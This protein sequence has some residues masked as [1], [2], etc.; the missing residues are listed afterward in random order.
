MKHK[1]FYINKEDAN[2]LFEKVNDSKPTKAGT[3]SEVYIFNKYVVL[4]IRNIKV[5]NVSIRDD[6]LVYFDQLIHTLHEL[7]EDGVKVLPIL[8]YKYDDESEHGTGYIIQYKAK[9]KELYEDRLL[10]KF[11]AYNQNSKP[12][13]YVY[14]IEND[15][16]LLSR[17]KLISKAPQNHFNKFVNDIV[18]IGNKNILIDFMGK[19]NFFY[20]TNEGFQFI[21]LSSHTDFYYRMTDKH[22]DGAEIASYYAYTPCHFGEQSGVNAHIALIAK[23]INGLNEKEKN[24]LKKYNREILEKCKLALTNNNIDKFQ[25]EKA[26]QTIKFF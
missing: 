21:D 16:Y 24:D 1:L 5:R 4:K 9:G 18:S 2:E 23:S 26:L 22:F 12:N 13:K 17:T 10:A 20:D 7:Y 11:Y 6:E 14:S 19:S 8:G 15:R 3:N 25:I